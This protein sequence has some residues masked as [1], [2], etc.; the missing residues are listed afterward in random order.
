M[1]NMIT[2]EQFEQI[3]QVRKNAQTDDTPYI[4]VMD[5]NISANGDPNKTEIKPADY[6]VNFIFP[7]NEDFRP[8]VEAM[9]DEIV[10]T[11]NGFM[12]VR[13]VYK[14]VYLTPY[15]MSDAV[16]TGAIIWQYLHRITA[17]G[18]IKPLTYEEMLQ[19]MKA[20]HK[21][22]KEASYDLVASVLGISDAEKEF[23]APID[24][25]RVAFEIAM[26]TPDMVNSS[27]FFTEALS[28]KGDG[29]K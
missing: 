13:R 11:K 18:E 4:G 25:V 9:E 24:V 8:R 6:T 19:V 3:D 1:E 17:D 26:N 7:D 27:D 29:K 14:H 5:G 10:A 22:L 15:R 20:D 21:E 23:L 16:T 28:G 2:M 12:Q